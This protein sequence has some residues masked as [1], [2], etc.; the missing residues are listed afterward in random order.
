MK[1]SRVTLMNFKSFKSESIDFKNLM[2]L[3]GENNAGKSTILKALDLFF[4]ITK[5]LNSD[6]FNN[7]KEKIVIQVAF[8]NLNKEAKDFFNKYLLDDGETVIIRKEYFFE[9]EESQKLLAVVLEEK[10]K[11]FKEKDKKDVVAILDTNEIFPFASRDKNYHWKSSPFGWPA[12]AT[13]YLPDF[14]YVPAVKDVKEEMKITDKSRF[15]EIINSMLENVL[16]NE[17]LKK[18]NEEFAKLLIGANETQDGRIMQLKEF[19]TMLSEKL[20]RHMKGASIKLDVSPP[21]IKDVFQS[22]TKLMVNDG[23]L[24]PIE[25]KGHGMQRSVIFVIFRVYADLL[26]KDHGEKKR[27]RSLIFGI[28]EPEL[29]LHPQMQR[30]M[31]GILKEI[32]KSDQ[33]IFT[34]HSSFFVDMTEYPS[35][36]IVLKKTLEEGTKAIQYQAE[37]FAKEEEKNLFRLLNEF[38]PE[39]NEMFFGKKVVL[40]EGDTEKVVL[41]IIAKKIRDD[42][43]FHENSITIVEC[44]GKG[45]ISIFAKVLNS[46]GIPY[47]VIYDK[48]VGNQADNQEIESLVS[49]SGGIGRTEVIDPDFETLCK[50]SGIEIVKDRSK[51]FRAFKTFKDLLPEKI[52]NILKEIVERIFIH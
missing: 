23:V 44:G 43:I 45:T 27:T 30:T 29:Y 12:V 7:V 3:I 11:D 8:N 37:I 47:V 18:V 33:V 51:P 14:L 5:T 22:G 35:I 48:D 13:G 6:Y 52:P 20:S 31:F 17:A 16:E 21:S 41:P 28:E 46:F 32:S 15:G 1:I 40:V 42:Y 39:R 38:D 36:C 2:T 24:T 4:S 50:N 34:T 10:L 19:E 26:K 25:T 9:S 49:S